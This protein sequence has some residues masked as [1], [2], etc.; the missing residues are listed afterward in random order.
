MSA[1][2]RMCEG[3]TVI[4]TFGKVS[5]LVGHTH[6]LRLSKIDP[7]QFEVRTTESIVELHA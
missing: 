2:L 3:I 1:G 4:K 6:R 5:L 7:E